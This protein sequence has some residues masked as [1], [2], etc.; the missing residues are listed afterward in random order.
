[1]ALKIAYETI[2]HYRVTFSNLQALFD[3]V[4]P[5]PYDLR[6]D[7][8]FQNGPRREDFVTFNPGYA[9]VQLTAHANAWLAGER[10]DPI[11]TP[12]LLRTLILG[13]HLP[14]GIWDIEIDV[15]L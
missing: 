15:D 9:S 12:Y 5:E 3:S 10:Y 11:L 7:R 14:M 4:L 8:H 1:M 2:P 6:R 13:R